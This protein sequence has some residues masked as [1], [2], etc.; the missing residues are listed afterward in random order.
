MVGVL[1]G[2]QTEQVRRRKPEF[3]TTHAET[4]FHLFPGKKGGAEDW[5]ERTM[6]VRQRQ[7]TQKV[8]RRMNTRTRNAPSRT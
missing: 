6:P 1:S 3:G 5:Q 7:E 8:L 2:S 4:G